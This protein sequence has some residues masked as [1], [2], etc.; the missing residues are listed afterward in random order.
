[1]YLE[2][3]VDHR[4]QPPLCIDLLL[5]SETKSLDA[6]HF[7][8]VTKYGLNDAKSLAVVVAAF[9]TIYFLLHPFND[10]ILSSFCNTQLDIHL[11]GGALV[12]IP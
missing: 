11:A 2:Y 3:V 12:R 4:H 9:L 6:N 7:S 10:C 8:D 1:V 5:A